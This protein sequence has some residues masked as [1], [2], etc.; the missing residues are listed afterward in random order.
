MMRHSTLISLW[1][2][3]YNYINH[4]KQLTYLNLSLSYTL[5]TQS[6]YKLKLQRFTLNLFPALLVDIQ[7]NLLIS[8]MH[9][10]HAEKLEKSFF[11]F[12]SKP[13]FGLYDLIYWGNCGKI[14]II[15]Q[16]MKPTTSQIPNYFYLYNT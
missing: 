16:S 7:L 6:K 11:F 12:G 13:H 15:L 14:S 10:I 8:E 1:F 9:S 5:H 2:S 3:L 4:E